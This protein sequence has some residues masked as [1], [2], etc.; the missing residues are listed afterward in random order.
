MTRTRRLGLAAIAVAIAACSEDVTVEEGS[1]GSGG[2]GPTSTSGVPSTSGSSTPAPA[3]STSAGEQGSGVVVGQGGGGE[4]GSSGEGGA[5]DPYV[6]PEGAYEACEGYWAPMID[7]ILECLGPTGEYFYGAPDAVDRLADNC[8]QV[9]FRGGLTIEEQELCN[10]DIAAMSSCDELDAYFD[11]GS[12][13]CTATIFGDAEIGAPC[14]TPYEC[15]SGAC[16]VAPNATCGT[17]RPAAGEG[18]ACDDEDTL[19]A[20]YLSCVG[21]LCEYRRGLGEDCDG[22]TFCESGLACVGGACD[23][24][25]AAGEPCDPQAATYECADGTYCNLLTGICDPMPAATLGGDC[26]FLDDGRLGVCTDGLRCRLDAQYHGECVEPTADGDACA[27]NAPILFTT[28]CAMPSTC[29]D[30]ECALRGDA[31]SCF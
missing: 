3:A 31:L 17:C 25:I 24:P 10:A 4:G 26:G 20:S 23:E 19:C 27:P 29:F 28:E 5:I 8:A 2:A 1:G 21:G 14:V 12:E 18:E 6:P 30:F 22:E 13:A 11:R 16:Y 15:S 7:L 9:V